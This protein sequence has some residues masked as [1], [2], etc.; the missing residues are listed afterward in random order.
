MDGQRRRQLVLQ[1]FDLLRRALA[2][3]AI[4]AF[5][6]ACICRSAF[7]SACDRA[8]LSPSTP[9]AARRVA[10]RTS[11]LV[12][13]GEEGL[14]AVVVGLADGVELV[15]VAARAAER[16]AEE[17]RA[18]DVGHLGQHFVAAAGD[19]LVAGVLAQRA[20]AVEA[21]GDRAVSSFFGVDLVAGELLA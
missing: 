15:I 3:S 14:H 19:F 11:L 16:H 10:S 2:F 17:R 8:R 21:G 4:R 9:P 12:R 18:D 7:I 1:L 13:R 6:A 5:A 20:E